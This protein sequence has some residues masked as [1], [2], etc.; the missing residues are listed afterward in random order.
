MGDGGIFMFSQ[1]FG[2]Y[3]VNEGVISDKELREVLD[4]QDSTKV[5]LGTIAVAQGYMTENEA[6]EVNH[7][8]TQYD[9]RFGDIAVE[10]GYLSERE[11]DELLE[12]QGNAFMKFLQIMFEK[13][14]IHASQLDEYLTNFQTHKGFSN[15][16]MKALKCDDID[17]IVPL[18]AFSAKPYVTDIVALILRNITRFV[19]QDY[20]IGSI[21]HVDTLE[22]KSIIG[23]KTYGTHG[24]YTA[25]ASTEKEDGL[26][27]LAS[28]FAK[29]NLS[30]MDNYVYDTLSEFVNMCLGLFV[31]SISKGEL[32]IDIEPP[33]VYVNQSVKGDGYVI[34]LYIHG[35]EFMLFV[36]VDSELAIG[37]QPY[38]I[39]IQKRAGSEATPD[40]KGTIMIVDDSAFIRKVLRNI[41]EEEGY[42]VVCEAVNGQEAVD[43][44]QEYKP[45]IV[46]MDITMPIMD[47]VT[48]LEQIKAYDSA[49]NVIMVTSA[50]QQKKVIQALKTGALQF[51]MKPL[52]KDEIVKALSEV[53]G[54]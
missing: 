19:T 30:K 6:E 26:I 10:R 32:F 43:L 27:A 2:E 3:L 18:F 54:K 11:V 21:R 39:D 52:D 16:E 40:S 51:C 46:T 29:E 22:Y 1:L 42:C 36:A 5:R 33:F 34:P 17:G 53:I 7:L 35:K 20:Y 15:D 25:V 37:Q 49:A 45:D 23:Q 13:D 31:T 12:Q 47:G 9:R 8:Q 4:E 44:Y 28:D 14:Y 48:A 24:I 50:G 38:S 41:V